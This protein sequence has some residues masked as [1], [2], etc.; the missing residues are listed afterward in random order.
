[1]SRFIYCYAVC[2]YSECHYAE[3]RNTECCYAECRV[4]ICYAVCHYAKC[5]HAECRSAVSSAR[6]WNPNK[7]CHPQHLSDTF[8]K[9]KILLLGAVTTGQMA[10]SQK[11]QL[12]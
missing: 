1:M 9:T 2:H 10:I 7:R 5:R 11:E 8:L 4:F 3:C 6:H 12:A